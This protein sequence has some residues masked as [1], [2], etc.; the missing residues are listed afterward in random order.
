MFAVQGDTTGLS[1][2]GGY[3]AEWIVEDPSTAS[4]L[5]SFANYTTVTFSN[6]A[7]SLSSWDLSADEG[8]EIV[9]D[10]TVLST[11]SLPGNDEFSVSNSGP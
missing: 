10:A 3:T 11:P 7:T 6:L 8:W 1:Y 2:S 5:V 4:G 9:Q